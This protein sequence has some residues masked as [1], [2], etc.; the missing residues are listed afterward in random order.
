LLFG[1]TTTTRVTDY[2]TQERTAPTLIRIPVIRIR[3]APK[4]KVTGAPHRAP[5]A[6]P[7][8]LTPPAATATIVAEHQRGAQGG[9]GI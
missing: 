6:T 7:K 9:S 1:S 8:A 4:P 2:P 5:V 3:T